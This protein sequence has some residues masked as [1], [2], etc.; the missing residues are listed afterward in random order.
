MRAPTIV[1]AAGIGALQLLA[2]PRPAR[3]CSC[4]SPPPPLEAASNSTAVFEGRSFAITRDGNFVRYEFE[5]IRVWKGEIGTRVTVRSAASPAMCGRS[6][7]TGVPYVVYAG[8][9]LD[10]DLSDTL[11]S[12]TRKSTHASEDLELLGAA[13]TPHASPAPPP[14]KAAMRE[15]PRIEPPPVP[16][17]TAGGRGCSIVGPPAPTWLIALAFLRRRP[18]KGPRK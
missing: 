15:P 4:I 12:R 17:S 3:A 13:Q 8:Q 2:A 16:T 14:S 11:C 18:R 5:V 7:D 1:V 10:G 9:R 6:F